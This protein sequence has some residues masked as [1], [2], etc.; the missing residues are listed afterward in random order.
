MIT[1]LGRIVHLVYCMWP[2]RGLSVCISVSF[3]F[4]FEGVMW[5]LNVIPD[6]YFSIY[7]A[8]KCAFLGA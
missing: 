3:P 8:C 1:C 5:D 7:F 6:H 2:F 4:S